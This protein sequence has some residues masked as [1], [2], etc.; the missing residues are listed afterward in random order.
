MP[1]DAGTRDVATALALIA[2][3]TLMAWNTIAGG[4]NESGAQ[5]VIESVG[6]L[7]AAEELEPE[8][9]EEA[10]REDGKFQ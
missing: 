9:M 5:S 7:A 8:A 3:A 4:L 2:I 1:G 6:L 10:K